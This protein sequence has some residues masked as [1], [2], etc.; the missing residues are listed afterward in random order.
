MAKEI[1]TIKLKDDFDFIRY[2]ES[3]SIFNSFRMNGNFISK[4]APNE[5]DIVLCYKNRK[6]DFQSEPL[7]SYEAFKIFHKYGY[8]Y[9]EKCD[10]I[11][12]LREGDGG[13]SDES[14]HWTQEL[15]YSDVEGDPD[16]L[17]IGLT[18]MFLKIM[19]VMYMSQ[20]IH[21][22]MIVNK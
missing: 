17:K 15:D 3:L 1:S 14:S 6:F 8:D 9:F 2:I 21:L 4:E 11:A 12:E 16:L 5:Y 10:D 7:V 19:C 20:T 13:F 22:V 18:N